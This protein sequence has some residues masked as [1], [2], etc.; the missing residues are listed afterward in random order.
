QY[1]RDHW[2]QI[3]ETPFDGT[4]IVVAVDRQGWR[5]GKR[6]TKH[7]LGWQVMGRRSFQVE[8]FREAITDLKAAQWRTCTDNFLPVILS[9]AQSA[10]E[11]NWFD[12]QRWRTIANNFRVLAG[13]GAAANLKGLILDPEH[14]RYALFSYAAQRRQRDESFEEYVEVA[15]RRG[16]EVMTAIAGVMPQAVLLSLFGHSLPLHSLLQDGKS[17][18]HVDYALLPAF[19]DGLLEVM[20]AGAHL[21]DG[22]EF[23]YPFKERQQFVDA[24]RRISEAARRL[25]AVPDRYQDKVRAGFGLWLDYKKQAN[26]FT[27]EEF[28]QAVRAALEVSDKYVWIYS[29]GPRFFPPSGIQVS[30]IEALAQ[31][32]KPVRG[33]E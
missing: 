21:V 32:R 14:Y 27:P 12:E 17:L 25:S 18:R 19:Y 26:Y 20:P 4:G 23:S 13:I 7:Q 24:H 28:G 3:E 29:E 31:A 9:A 8:E 2:R 10:A 16:R 22:Y 33:K 1:V 15:R 5:Q 30:Y 6:E 11:L